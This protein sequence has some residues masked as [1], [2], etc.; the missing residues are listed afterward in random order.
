MMSPETRWKRGIVC[1]EPVRQLDAHNP[2]GKKFTFLLQTFS[3]WHNLVLLPKKVRIYISCLAVPYCLDSQK[4]YSYLGTKY[5]LV[6][7]E[8]VE[9]KALTLYLSC[10]T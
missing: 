7:A 3:I 4:L 2:K 9:V 5:L 8:I 10:C 6:V 1:A